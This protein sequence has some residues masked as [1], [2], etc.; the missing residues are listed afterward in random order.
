MVIFCNF[1]PFIL[2]VHLF[3]HSCPPTH[4]FSPP[5]PSL[6]LLLL[7]FLLLCLSP[8]ASCYHLPFLQKVWF[9]FCTQ[10][11]EANEPYLGSLLGLVSEFGMDKGPT[12]KFHQVR[13]HFKPFVIENLQK[14]GSS[15]NSPWSSYAD[16]WGE[17]TFV[18]FNK[19]QPG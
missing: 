15:W 19:Y 13:S 2:I 10:H 14:K 3:I 9:A 6:L 8:L 1:S 16:M 7:H 11:H 5:I 18:C 12:D 17:D 4:S